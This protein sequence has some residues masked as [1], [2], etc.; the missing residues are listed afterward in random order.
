MV[1]LTLLPRK[2]PSS[3][4]PTP[5]HFSGFFIWDDHPHLYP[6][7]PSQGCSFRLSPNAPM[8]SAPLPLPGTLNATRSVRTCWKEGVTGAGVEGWIA[9]CQKHSMFSR[10]WKQLLQRSGDLSGYRL[11]TQAEGPSVGALLPAWSWQKKQNSLGGTPK[12][13]GCCYWGRQNF[14]ISGWSLTLLKPHW[15]MKVCS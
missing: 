12:G 2:G 9:V 11:W 1:L 13:W 14:V 3:T 10:K 15:R 6:Q 7:H 8:A 4:H 5:I